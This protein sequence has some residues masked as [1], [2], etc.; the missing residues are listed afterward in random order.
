MDQVISHGKV[1]RGYMG[2][3]PE[4]ITPAM[5]KALHLTDMRGVLMGDVTAGS[6]A[7]QAGIQRGDIVYEIN[8]ERVDDGNQ[9]RLRIS[10]TAPGT[11]V[12]LKLSHDGAER[13]VSVKLAEY[14]NDTARNAGGNPGGN[15]GNDFRE[16]GG[17]TNALDGVQVEDL[18][19]QYLHELRLP[20][21]TKG[22]V[23]TDVANG[24]PAAMAGLQSGDVVQEMDR[25]RIT[26]AA[27]FD[28]AMR[29]SAGRTVLLLINRGGE[30]RFFAVEPR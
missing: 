22:V 1:T 12:R 7:A 8:G 2:V 20:S 11:T 19:Y 9:L 23:V 6:P 28:R 5:A 14:P 13:T 24:S 18:N 10:S 15:P 26:S 4:D 29:R 25:E 21:S 17:A 30:T 27:D 16:N 3:I